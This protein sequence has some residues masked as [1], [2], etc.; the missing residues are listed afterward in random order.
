M[1]GINSA[2]GVKVGELLRECMKALEAAGNDNP[3]FEAEQLVMKFCGVKRS[4]ILMF[5]GLEVT[6]EQ[7]EEVRGAV[8][9]RNSG[10]PLQY[11]L[12]EWE[13]YG[14][15]FYVGEGVLIPRQDTE[16]LVETAARFLREHPGV[17]GAADLCA[18]SGCVGIT[19]AKLTGI[20][21]KL[22]ELSEQALGYLRRNIALNGAEE[23]C[24]AMH[25][26]V[27]SDDTAVGMP[28]LDLIVTNPPYLT[29][30]DMQEL[31]PEVTHEPETALFGG[32][33]GLDYYRR[34]VP[35][36]GAKLN[37]GG[38]LAAEIG[39]GQHGDVTRIFEDNGLRAGFEKDLCGVIRVIYGIKQ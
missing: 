7:A 33:D 17:S 29:A 19:L 3:R 26:D 32:E 24:E 34:M 28:Q 9:R 12:G 8:Q 38:M 36:W 18:G 2:G 30:Q 6:A 23:L 31:Q 4:D 11:I 15:P 20:P 10:E 21:V 16:T 37:P 27:L 5:P 39:M 14:L 13:F 1:S 25:A 22:L 35:L